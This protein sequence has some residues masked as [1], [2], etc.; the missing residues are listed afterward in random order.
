[1]VSVSLTL[2]TLTEDHSADNIIIIFQKAMLTS[3]RRGRH[4]DRR[5]SLYRLTGFCLYRR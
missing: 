5:P 2:Y 3:V 4:R 1:M